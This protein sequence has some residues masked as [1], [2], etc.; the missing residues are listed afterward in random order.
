M[1]PYT[2]GYDLQIPISEEAIRSLHVG[3][4]VRLYG[5]VITARDAAHKYIKDTLF[6]GG[7]IAEADQQ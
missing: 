7:A 5:T 2:V 6:K 4:Q 1:S 3:D